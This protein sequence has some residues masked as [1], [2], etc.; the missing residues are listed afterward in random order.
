MQTRCN[1]VVSDYVRE[2]PECD[3]ELR[4]Y[5]YDGETYWCCQNIKCGYEECE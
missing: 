2:C 5:E 4:E 1:L 3:N